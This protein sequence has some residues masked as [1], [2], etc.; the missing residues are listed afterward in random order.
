MKRE[1][2]VYLFAVLLVVAVF[3]AAYFFS[4]SPTG[5]A[6]YSGQ[7]DLSAG[8]YNNTIYSSGAVSLDSSANATSG[9]YT[10]QVIDS[11]D[12]NTTWNNLTWTG[13]VPGNATL[14]FQVTSC[15]DSS[16][17]DASFEGV[18]SNNNTLDLSGFTGQYLQ[19][20][21]LFSI[22]NLNTSS[23]SLTG[24]SY[25]Y[26]TQP[27]APEEFSITV[28]SPSDGETYNSGHVDLNVS[29]NGDV[30]TWWYSLNDGDNT[31]FTPNT[32]LDVVDGSNTLE[33]YANSTEGN[34]SSQSMAFTANIPVCSE[35]DVTACDNYLDCNNVNGYWWD[36]NTCHTDSQ[37]SSSSQ[38]QQQEQQ[39][40]TTQQEQQ[41]VQIQQITQISLGT[42]SSQDVVQGD[43]KD[44]SLSVQNSGTVAVSSCS[45]SFTGDSAS[46]ASASSGAQDISPGASASYP[47]TVAV[48]LDTTPGAYDIGMSVSCAET[49]GTGSFTVNVIEK[50]LDFN[51]TNVQRTSQTKV[52]V[53]YSLKDLSGQDQNVSLFF[54]I[55]DNSSAD[56]GNVSQNKT[57]GAN[58]S[59]NYNVNIPINESLEGN[60]TLSANVNLEQ[61]SN[62]VS[63]PITL[64]APIGGF[65]IFGGQGGAGS[66]IV[67]IVVVLIL[68]VVFF[69][70][71]R[72]RTAKSKSSE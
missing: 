41:Q 62:S 67:L 37:S 31:T 56:V 33:I 61:Y 26:T 64:G 66:L 34:L 54:S 42:V 28:E 39:N 57:L 23:P 9:S 46:W 35:T 2:G 16:C 48:P 68:G 27:A 49:S 24:V 1:V 63:E 3:F 6:V 47:F 5:F 25:A 60:L 52:R 38:Q 72:M 22:P 4:I 19:Y 65:A 51:I 18:A 32:S 71:R 7:P 29:A 55:L 30:A 58:K 10:S 43:S 44:L 36:D 13:T 15:S 45:L 17:S 53:D 40:T 8:T 59:G 69:L 20:M 12:S 70:V 21:V 11:N 50:T 14:T